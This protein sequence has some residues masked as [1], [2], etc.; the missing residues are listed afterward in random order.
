MSFY[1]LNSILH[2]FKSRLVVELKTN[3]KAFWWYSNSGMKTKR[4][5][6]TCGTLLTLLR[7]GLKLKMISSTHSSLASLLMKITQ[8]YISFLIEPYH[9]SYMMM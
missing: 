1:R 3:L 7:A 2:N 6:G 9:L 4:K 5:V 8:M